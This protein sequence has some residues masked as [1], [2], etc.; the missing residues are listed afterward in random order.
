MSLLM[1]FLQRNATNK[2]V[3]ATLRCALV[4]NTEMR[5]WPLLG[6]FGGIGAGQKARAIRTVAGLFAVHTAHCEKGN[7]GT[8]CRKLCSHDEKPWENIDPQGKAVPPGPMGRRFLYLINAD[9]NEI[10]ERVCRLVRYAK[11]RDVPVN[12]AALEKDL[13]EWPKAREAWAGE[14]WASAEKR[15]EQEGET[16]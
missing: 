10:F 16:A 2:R 3:L 1:D 15:E 8:L 13:A 9:K 7:M 4:E 5:A 12:Y 6:S 14:F 11:S